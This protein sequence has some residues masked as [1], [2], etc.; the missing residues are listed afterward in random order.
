MKGVRIESKNPVRTS[1]YL[2]KGVRVRRENSLEAFG[3]G[4]IQHL[5]FHVEKDFDGD[6]W[7]EICPRTHHETVKDFIFTLG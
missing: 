4:H 6:L 7:T 5:L 1:G 3:P 2:G